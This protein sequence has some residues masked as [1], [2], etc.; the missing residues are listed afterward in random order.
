MSC[1]LT[2]VSKAA[3]R[4]S[5]DPFSIRLSSYEGAWLRLNTLAFTIPSRAT[6]VNPSQGKVLPL[7][8]A[9][10]AVAVRFEHPGTRLPTQRC[11]KG[12]ASHRRTTGAGIMAA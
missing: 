3:K 12:L 7:A 10:A 1:P 2:F 5:S 11:S 6:A 4:C 9:G 8:A